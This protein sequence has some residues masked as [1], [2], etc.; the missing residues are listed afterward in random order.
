MSFLRDQS[1]PI[2]QIAWALGVKFSTLSDWN[3]G[4]DA[5]MKPYE[6]PDDRGK[7]GKVTA[8][9][10]GCVVERAKAIKANNQRLRVKTFTAN[11]RAE[12]FDLGRKTIE[13][14]LI[15]NDLWRPQTRKRRPR[16]YQ[17]LC[18]RIPNGLLSIDGSDMVVWLDGMKF[19]FNV[20]LGVDVGSFCHTGFGLHPT[21]TSAAVMDVIEQ[22]RRNWGKPVGVLCDHGSANLNEKVA[23]YL[24]EC[25]IEVVPAGPGNPKG[26]GTDEGAFGQM[27][28]AIGSICLNTSSPQ[29]LAKSVL[30][31]LVSVYIKMRNQ[32]PLRRNNAVPSDQMQA[33]VTDDEKQAEKQR[34]ADH[35]KNKN[36]DDE[37]GDKIERLDWIIN[38]YGLTPTSAEHDRARHCIRYYDLEAISKTEKAFLRAVSRQE[39]RRNL[40]YFFGILRN[41]QQEVDDARYRNYCRC[42][43][44]YETMRQNEKNR[45]EKERQKDATP[46]I[47]TL[48]KMAKEAVV[49]PAQNM[50]RF[51]LKKVK[52]WTAEICKSA[53]YMEP[54]K[55]KI[56]EAIGELKGLDNDQQEQV[57]KT[58]EQFINQK[59][60]A[61]SVTLSA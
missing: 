58:I 57:W 1:R 25:G 33:P 15:A 16:Y 36:A 50:R 59:S 34:I 8:E 31:A 37:N 45:H 61:E 41:I 23:S 17:N 26:N 55:K 11:L 13:Q 27:K 9:V 29:A 60:K 54:V 46:K 2:R 49:G 39:S 4:F 6:L 28:Q 32:L 19:T 56:I 51:A 48:V 18:Q 35:K 20:E 7:S 30:E 22:H 40:A 21:E 42:R 12:G 14:I 24:N 53:R 47:E 52:Q 38:Y 5:H 3:K 10:V 44:N 43:Y